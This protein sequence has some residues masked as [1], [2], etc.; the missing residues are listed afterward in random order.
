MHYVDFNAVQVKLWDVRDKPSLVASQDMKIGALFAAAFCQEQ[1]NLY[2]VGGAKGE[3]VVWDVL[4][5][6]SVAEKFGKQFA[7]RSSSISQM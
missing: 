3:V 7:Q 1:P 6:N 4:S 2:A 5:S